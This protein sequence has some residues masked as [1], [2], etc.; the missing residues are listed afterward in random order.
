MRKVSLVIASLTGHGFVLQAQ[1]PDRPKRPTAPEAVGAFRFP[2]VVAESLPNGLRVRI[3]EDHSVPVVAVR[4]VVGADSTF[5]PPGKEGLYAV[6]LGAMR[7]ATTR[8][9]TERLAAA[10]AALGT[11]I[12]PTSF[13]TTT[14]S[15]A[16]A[17]SIMGEMLMAPSLDSA[18]VERRKAIQMAAAR[19]MTQTPSLAPRR[20]F[21]RLLYGPGDPFARSLAPTE[22]SIRS[23]ATADVRR[24]YDGVIVPRTTTLIVTG[25]ISPAAALAEVRR[26][27]GPW[28]RR[29]PSGFGS[30]QSS[31]PREVSRIHL[32]DVPAQQAYVYVGALGPFRSPEPAAAADLLGAVATTRLQQELR[33]KRALMY[34]GTI[35]LT[36]RRSLQPSAFVGS[37]LVDPRKVDTVLVGWLGLLAGLRDANPPTPAEVEAG[38]RARLGLL[39]ARFDGADSVASRLVELVRDGLSADYFNDW[40]AG[41]ASAPVADV[42][43]AAR[44]IIDPKQLIIVISGDRR[45]IE[46]ALRAAN[47]GPIVVVDADGRPK[48]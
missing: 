1:V 6:T 44:R 30:W 35:G 47:L 10:A 18:L 25:D 37:A 40:V 28:E 27:F 31:L 48:P 13:T 21:Y 42:A 36:W 46:P 14:K 16:G 8:R 4:A 29:P 3:V 15:F 24:F 17:L 20:L 26:V 5:D 12:T 19:R 23:I 39:P 43:N 7:E 33:D 32:I 34:S 41:L 45:I 11:T 9:S 38:R 22:A 2:T